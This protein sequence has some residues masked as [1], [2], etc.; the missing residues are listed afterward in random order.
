[1][2][3]KNSGQLTEFLFRSLETGDLQ[4]A[5]G[6]VHER[7]GGDHDGNRLTLRLLE[8]KQKEQN[9]DHYALKA[10]SIAF[11]WWAEVVELI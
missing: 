9:F 10:N 8:C 3:A 11:A 2:V 7:R 1:M 4:G 6:P 5:I